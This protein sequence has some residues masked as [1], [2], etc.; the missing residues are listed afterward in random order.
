MPQATIDIDYSEFQATMSELYLYVP[1]L[2]PQ[3]C[4]RLFGL[5]DSPAKLFRFENGPAAVRA[6]VTFLLKPTD[7]LLDL[8]SACR[9]GDFKNLIIEGETSAHG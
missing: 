1:N 5:F 2:P 7:L 4:D 6:G 9:T 3:I 8:L